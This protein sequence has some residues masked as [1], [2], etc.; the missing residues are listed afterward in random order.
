M[1][2]SRLVV[3]GEIGCDIEDSWQPTANYRDVARSYFSVT[4]REWIE[5]ASEPWTNW[6][7]FLTL[8][9]E[10]EARLKASG[11]ALG[12]KL[13]VTAS[14]MKDP[15]FRE[16]SISCFRCGKD[17]RYVLALCAPEIQ[18]TGIGLCALRFGGAE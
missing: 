9:V 2:G 10:K 8:F 5:R 13:H 7:R 17:E 1:R 11:Y 12:A 6:D 18:A 16:D 4:E 3:Q 14:S 15:P